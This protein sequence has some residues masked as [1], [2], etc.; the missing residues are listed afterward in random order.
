M[1]KEFGVGFGDFFRGAGNGDLSLLE[2]DGAIAKTQDVIHGM[3]DEDDGLLAVER[4]KIIITLFLEGS[5]A[6][7]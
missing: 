5:V 2:H 3:G 1:F 7:G 6:D 4:S